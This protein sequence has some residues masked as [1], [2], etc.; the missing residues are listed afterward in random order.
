[1][2]AFKSYYLKYNVNLFVLMYASV[3]ACKCAREHVLGTLQHL[4]AIHGTDIKQRSQ[5]ALT[6]DREESSS[7]PTE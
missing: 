2:V 4:V 5:R 7:F 6:Q 3:Q 1:M